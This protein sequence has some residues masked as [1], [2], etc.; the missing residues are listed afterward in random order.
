MTEPQAWLI[1]LA[2]ALVGLFGIIM[3]TRPIRRGFLRSWL[4]GVAALVLL[5]PAPVPGFESYFAPAFLVMLFEALLQRDGQPAWAASLLFSG[6]ALFTL[7][8]GGYHHWRRRRRRNP[9]RSL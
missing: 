9:Y 2:A 7:M 6:I 3:L 5:L 8:L 4:R 1:T